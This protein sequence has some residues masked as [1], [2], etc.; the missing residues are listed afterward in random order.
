MRFNLMGT[1]L[2]SDDPTASGNWF[3]EHFGFKVNI[4]LGWYVNTQHPDHPTISLDFM[5]RGHDSMPEA[6]RDKALSGTLVAF[7]VEDVD[8]E[9]QRLREAGVEIVL[10][11]HTEPWGQR[12]F[13]VAG[14]DNVFV[15]VLQLVAPD[16]AWLAENGLG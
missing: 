10:P 1:A 14:P 15:E 4:D 13:Q 12:R 6:L 8:A 3:A 16:P 11:L 7:L 9:E 5:R 2:N